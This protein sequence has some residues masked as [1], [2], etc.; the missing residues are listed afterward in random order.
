MLYISILAIITSFLIIAYF[1]YQKVFLYCCNS[2]FKNSY[3]GDFYVDL[4]GISSCEARPFIKQSILPAENSYII[5]WT[6]KI[7]NAIIFLNYILNHENT[8]YDKETIC[9]ITSSDYKIKHNN[10]V[11]KYNDDCTIKMPDMTITYIDNNIHAYNSYVA[12]KQFDFGSKFEPT[13]LCSFMGINKFSNHLRELV[14]TAYGILDKSPSD[15]YYAPT[16]RISYSKKAIHNLPAGTIEPCDWCGPY[17]FEFFATAYIYDKYKSINPN[18]V[19]FE[20]FI[21][22]NEKILNLPNFNGDEFYKHIQIHHQIENES[23][24]I[25]IPITNSENAKYGLMCDKVKSRP[26]YGAVDKHIIDNQVKKISKIDINIISTKKTD[27]DSIF[28][29]LL[30][31]IWKKYEKT[32]KNCKKEKVVIY[33][34]RINREFQ[35]IQET[36]DVSSNS[37]KTN[38]KKEKT[39][40]KEIVTVEQKQINQSYKSFDTLYLRDKDKSYLKAVLERFHTN[41]DIYTDLDIQRKIGILLHGEPGTGKTS[42]IKTI[43]SYLK[44][45]IYYIDL[46]NIKKNS[47]LKMLFDHVNKG[48]G[49]GG[50]IVFEDID[51]MTNIVKPRKIIENNNTDVNNDVNNDVN[52]DYYHV[53]NIEAVDIIKT[54]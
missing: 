41:P 14:Q 37:I 25:D 1:R 43:A 53:E 22:R 4:F 47:E 31:E 51:C 44:R 27:Y 19:L 20:L 9:D 28:M 10:I 8:V 23:L 2:K 17:S 21:I 34:L 46:S 6:P 32:K 45:N 49:M 33:E 26:S 3:I 40:L 12:E 24:N 16:T 42:T 15:N 48:N 13:C 38:K 52:D 36:P 39:K 11:F 29:N 18:I 54:E 30:D 5:Q 50:V 35:E 7:Q